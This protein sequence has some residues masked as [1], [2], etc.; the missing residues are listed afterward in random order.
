MEANKVYSGEH[1][2]TGAEGKQTTSFYLVGR[3]FSEVTPYGMLF[4]IP[5]VLYSPKDPSPLWQAKP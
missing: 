1:T 3:F 2:A 4:T 5:D